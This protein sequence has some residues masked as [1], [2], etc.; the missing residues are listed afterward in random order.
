MFSQLQCACLVWGVR[1]ML[2]L[3]LVLQLRAHHE[4][5]DVQ[6]STPWPLFLLGAYEPSSIRWLLNSSEVQQREDCGW[7][8]FTFHLHFL[9]QALTLVLSH[10]FT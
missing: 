7:C 2:L 5:T 6:Y 3:P 9:S 1:G 8:I 4:D 10:Q